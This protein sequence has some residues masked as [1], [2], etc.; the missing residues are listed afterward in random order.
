MSKRRKLLWI[1]LAG[2]IVGFLL[3]GDADA[4]E[5]G[6]AGGHRLGVTVR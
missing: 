3:G 6:R 5:S 1:A 2:V 4:S